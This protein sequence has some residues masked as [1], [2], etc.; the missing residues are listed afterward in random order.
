MQVK[1]KI[2]SSIA[3]PPAISSSGLAGSNLYSCENKTIPPHSQEL[4]KI[5]LEIEIPKGF[6]G[7]IV[8]RSGLLF[9]R[10]WEWSNSDFQ[11]VNQVILINHSS[12]PFSVNVGDK[13]AQLIFEKIESPI[14][15]EC[16][17]LSETE[18][19][20]EGFGSSGI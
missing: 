19:D 5:D 14:F 3:L 12:C 4:F 7:R 10:R 9:N 20:S 16:D 15:V 13:T 2:V 1:F 18:R 11:D 8:P 17:D 6:Y